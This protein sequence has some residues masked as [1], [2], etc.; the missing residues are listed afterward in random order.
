MTYPVIFICGATASGKSDFTHRLIDNYFPN[1]S[2]LSVDSMQVYK[3]LSVGTAKPDKETEKKYRYELIDIIDPKENFTLSKYLEL[4]KEV[5]VKMPKPIFAVGGTSLYFHGLIHGLFYEPD[6]GGVIRGKLYERI[7]KEGLSKLVEE[8]M[9]LDSEALNETDKS[10]PRR[11]IRAL[12][13]CQKTGIPF[14]KMKS[15]RKPILDIRFLRFYICKDRDKL[16]H[17]I[18]QRV[19]SMFA[20]GLLDEA[21]SL[22]DYG[23][24]MKCTAMQGI[25]YKECYNYLTEKSIDYETLVDTTQ[26]NTRHFAKRQLTWFNKDGGIRIENTDEC[27]RY[28]AS[29][30]RKFYSE[31]S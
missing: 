15:M 30:V 9:C 31:I 24:D 25:G 7:E 26:K 14:S 22:I 29:E 23:L 10:N 3:M 12:E 13:I 4:S 6:D 8:L 18:N 20:N 27:I 2:I 1:A 16:Y 11:V 5:L 21:R 28:V 19:L 17:D